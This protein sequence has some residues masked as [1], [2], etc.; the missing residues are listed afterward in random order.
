[1]REHHVGL[2]PETFL[3]KSCLFRLTF[4]LFRDVH[5]NTLASHDPLCLVAPACGQ[6]SEFE[7][8]D[9]RPPSG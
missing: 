4:L 6:E 8:S 9:N 7:P 1:V 3:R 2:C 5:P